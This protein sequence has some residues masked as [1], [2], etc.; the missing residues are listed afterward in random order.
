MFFGR[1]GWSWYTGSAQWLHKVAVADLIGVKATYDGLIVDPCVPVEW[2]IFTYTR[3]FRGSTYQFTFKRSEHLGLEV[4][5]TPIE[6]NLIPDFQDHQV[7]HIIVN[8][9]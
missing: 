9:K 5:G 4:D 7:H 1:G 3:K 2:N 6:G 8:F